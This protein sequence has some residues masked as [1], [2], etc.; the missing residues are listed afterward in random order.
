MQS[1]DP[2]RSELTREQR[3]FAWGRLILGQLQIV[4][5]TCTLILLLRIGLETVT[6]WCGAV[7]A[8]LVVASRLIFQEKKPPN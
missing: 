3:R 2:E 7:T 8:A 6:I 4:G 1:E 5:A